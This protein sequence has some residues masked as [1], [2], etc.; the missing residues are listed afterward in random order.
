M[1]S[2][3]IRDL[4]H[5]GIRWSLRITLLLQ[6]G[7]NFF[8]SMMPKGLKVGQTKLLCCFQGRRSTSSTAT[9]AGCQT[10]QGGPNNQFLVG[11]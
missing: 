6:V 9:T 4:Q 2:K 3:V 11:G 8:N 1:A 7:A 5:L 10:D